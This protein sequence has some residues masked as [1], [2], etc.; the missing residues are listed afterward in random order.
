MAIRTVPMT[1]IKKFSII[2]P[3]L[4]SPFHIDFEWWKQNDNDWRVFL[5][6]YLC[7]EHK[8]VF[9]NTNTDQLID[10]VDAETG[11]V[12]SLDGIQHTLIA[13]CA[14][15]PGFVSTNTAIVD[16]VFRT[17]LANENRPL[18]PNELSVL[19]GQP[20]NKILLTFGGFQVY[21]GIRPYQL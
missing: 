20:A 13:H 18:S 4:D 11:E 5:V 1:E 7:P 21:K 6:D 14:K 17:F 9:Q 16:A 19:I 8:E 3:T 10:W 12:H 2:K 15:E